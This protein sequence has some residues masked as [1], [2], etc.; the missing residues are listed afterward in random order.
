MMAAELGEVLRALPELGSAMQDSQSEAGRLLPWF[1]VLGAWL[2][3]GTFGV[4]MKFKSV[5]DAQVHPLI[6]QCYKTFWTFA[7]SFLVLTFEPFEFTWWGML[8]GISWVPAGVCAVIAVQNIGLAC[9]QAIWQ[10]TIIGTSFV[11]G[12]FIL[13]PHEQVKSVPGTALSLA[14]LVIGLLGM[15]YSFTLRPKDADGLLEG[16]GSV[17]ATSPAENGTAP[18]NGDVEDSHLRSRNLNTSGSDAARE[19]IRRTLSDPLQQRVPRPALVQG[20]KASASFAVGVGAAL[21]NGTWGGS[22]LVP[23]HYAP[24]HG[25]HFVISFAFG[26]VAANVLL[27][28]LYFSACK[29]VWKC[30]FPPF[31]FKVMAVPGA[32]SGLLWSAGNFFSLYVVQELGQ[33]IGYSLVQC[34]VI[35]SGLWGVCYYRE[36]SGRA[37]VYWCLGLLVCCGGIVGISMMKK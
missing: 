26:A 24:Y 12:F 16:R 14:A 37:V 6:F 19:P 23:S 11:W 33:G 27:V 32:C 3:F 18:T 28:V 22:N 4:P 30:D 5:V 36:M 10:V 35:I 31:Q 9:G 34:S 8:S 15:T 21:F 7:S 17:N 29:L 25:V 20:G 1:A 13:R 2:C